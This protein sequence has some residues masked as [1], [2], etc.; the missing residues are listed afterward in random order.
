M[1]TTLNAENPR[2]V[3]GPPLEK[4][5]SKYI[6]NGQSWNAGQLLYCDT[7]GR[8]RP[9]ASDA[10]AGTGGIKYIGLDTVTNPGNTTTTADVGVLTRDHI[11][12]G[13]EL[14][15][16]LTRANIGQYYALS[17]V[18][19]LCTLDADDTG[20]D[21]FEVVDLGYIFDEAQYNSTDIKAKVRFKILTTVLEAAPA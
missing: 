6:L 12:E 11:L 7:S 5:S 8:L 16:T 10:D 15:G 13:N 20:N 21:A 2:V 17:V 18:T 14:D 19:G 4:D 3:A 1:A 9:C